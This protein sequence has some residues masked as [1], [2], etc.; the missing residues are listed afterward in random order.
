MYKWN[1]NIQK[2]IE[3]IENNITENPSL[4]DMSKQI[5]YSPYYCSTQFHEI[6]GLTLK[7][8]M[9]GRRLCLATMEIRDTNKRIL[10]IAIKYGYSSQEALTRAFATAYGC[11]PYL[12]RKN[13]RPL[14][15]SIKQTVLFPEYLSLI[16]I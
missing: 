1:E 7:S 8:Y 16:H 12:Y 14:H 5:G 15:L 13:P 2:I 6:V 10:D 4:L 11:T 9:A 3:W